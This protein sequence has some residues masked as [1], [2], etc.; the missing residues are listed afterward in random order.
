[1]KQVIDTPSGR[2]TISEDKV[3]R[4]NHYTGKIE[5]AV[6]SEATAKF[7]EQVKELLDDF[8]ARL[9]QTEINLERL[10][11]KLNDLSKNNKE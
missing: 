3:I 8:Y 9:E 10:E 1:M 6:F 7:P 2:V 5:T 4:S 11:E